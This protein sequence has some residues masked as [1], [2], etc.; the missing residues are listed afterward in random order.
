MQEVR[1]EEDTGP[2]RWGWSGSPMSRGTPMILHEA[3]GTRN[4][5]KEFLLWA[6][7]A[8][9]PANTLILDF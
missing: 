1:R 5:Q 8:D 3:P 2:C 7:K 9:G 6:P 4:R